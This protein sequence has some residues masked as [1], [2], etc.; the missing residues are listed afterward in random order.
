MTGPRRNLVMPLHADSR[1]LQVRDHKATAQHRSR[2][3]V[4]WSSSSTEWRPS[5]P[6][7]SSRAGEARRPAAPFTR[8]IP[9]DRVEHGLMPAR[10]HFGQH[11]ALLDAVFFASE[12]QVLAG[13]PRET[14]PGGAD[15]IFNAHYSLVVQ[16]IAEI[17]VEEHSKLRQ[18][19][20][21]LNRILDRGSGPMRVVQLRGFDPLH[22]PMPSNRTTK[23]PIA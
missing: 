16:L 10:S 12:R 13:S 9:S 5:L 19:P 21:R 11:K 1:P 14:D 18:D 2:R 8:R 6:T 23:H 4:T 3:R 22:S 15:P 7:L 17:Y 20:N